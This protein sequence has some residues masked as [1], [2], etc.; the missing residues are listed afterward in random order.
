MLFENATNAQAFWKSENGDTVG[1][2]AFAK[3][4]TVY[5]TIGKSGSIIAIDPKTM[6][7]KD[8]FSEPA[9]DFVSTPVLFKYKDKDLLAASS[10]DGRMF[11]LDSASLGSTD[12]RTPLHVSAPV[13]GK[14]ITDIATWEADGIRWL[15]GTSNNMVIALKLSDVNDVP[16]VQSSWMSKELLSPILPAVVN[17]VVFTASTGTRST[18]GVLYALDGVTGKELWNSGK[19]LTGV[20]AAGALWTSVGQVHTA[21][22]DGT[23]YTF[24][25][26]L[27]RY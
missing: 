16:A 14:A 12:H 2:P 7:T 9:A 10:R 24:G 6:Q 25:F 3:D 20:V 22:T 8:W 13:P 26:P 15:L 19:T 1:A 17:G 5:V 21:T 11:L 18:P 23:L 4:G 27:E